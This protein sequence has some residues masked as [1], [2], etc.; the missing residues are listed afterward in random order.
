MTFLVAYQ[1]LEVLQAAEDPE[2]G[3]ERAHSHEEYKSV[4][5]HGGPNCP[6]CIYQH[7]IGASHRARTTTDRTL[8]QPADETTR[9]W[10]SSST[11]W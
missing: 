5:A 4:L 8:I 1:F 6:L 2:S 3:K 11:K 9:R 10:Q 7:T